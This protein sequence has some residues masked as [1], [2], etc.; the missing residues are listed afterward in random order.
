MKVFLAGGTGVVGTRA[1]PAL[2][3]AGHDVTAVARSDEKAALVE[4]LG[5]TP[6]TVDLFDP[7]AVAGA[8]TGHEVVVNLA[9]SVPPLARSARKKAWAMH[10]RLRS[11]A[12]RNLVD[13]AL[14]AGAS[15]Y[16]QESICFPYLDAG[17]RW[18]DEDNPV[19]HDFWGYAPAGAAER[20]T[21]RFTASADGGVGVALRFAQFY[22]PGDSHTG[23]MNAALRRRLNPFWGDPDAFVSVIH[24]D[25]AAT[26]VAAAMTAPAGVYNVVDDE[27]LTRREAGRAAAAALGVKPPLTAPAWLW[28]ASP[29]S[30]KAIM[31]SQRVSH[32]RFTE[33]TGW[34]PAHPSIRTSWPTGEVAA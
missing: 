16:V 24:G 31:R 34:T 10:G 33:A 12:S 5:G 30:A 9:T 1:L 27:P 2:V 4:R 25:D 13:A 18:I 8:L 28:K 20:Q 3:A 7:A 23:P 11:E 21:A 22:A 17:D 14:A 29:P 6:V 26:A 19:D 15:R 32:A